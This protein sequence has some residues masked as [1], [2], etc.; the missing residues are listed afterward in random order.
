MPAWSSNISVNCK[1][2]SRPCCA[3]L[4]DLCEGFWQQDSPCARVL[5]YALDD[6][7]NA[8]FPAA[9]APLLRM[10]TALTADSGTA[11]FAA[12]YLRS[13]R[14]VAAVHESSDEVVAP[15]GSEDTVVATKAFAL[16]GLPIV[17]IPQV[18]VLQ[19]YA[20]LARSDMPRHGRRAHASDQQPCGLACRCEHYRNDPGITA[21]LMAVMNNRCLGCACRGRRGGGSLCRPVCAPATAA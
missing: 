2:T 8:L 6:A 11:L 9:P 4:S 14:G 7:R 1:I 10:L 21:G 17:T 5:H 19:C 3:E 13:L 15:N 12:Q 20:V 18:D 16:P